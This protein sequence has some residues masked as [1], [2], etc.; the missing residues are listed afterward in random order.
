MQQLYG[1]L[2]WWRRHSLVSLLL[3]GGALAGA[4]PKY[5]ELIHRGVAW[6]RNHRAKKIERYIPGQDQWERVVN[7]RF[8]F[9]FSYPRAWGRHTSTNNDGH[10][11]KH[12]AIEGIS[13]IGWGQHAHVLEDAGI[14]QPE[15]DNSYII[16]RSEISIPIRTSA[17][18]TTMVEAERT[19][20][21]LGDNRIMQVVV[22]HDDLEITVLCTAPSQYFD[23]FEA[24]FLAT[25]HS[26]ALLRG[27]EEVPS[28]AAAPRIGSILG[29]DN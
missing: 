24:T 23:E 25:C 10:T 8:G 12:P 26:L 18:L 3:T 21:D 14:S 19:V 1:L 22:E 11:I 28:L 9:A 29:A 17:V 16:S 4:I 7:S 27:A 5:L 2:D 20:L 6:S 13:V 15:V